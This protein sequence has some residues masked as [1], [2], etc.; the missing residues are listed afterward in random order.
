V[1]SPI[2]TESSEILDTL[3]KDIGTISDK[4]RTRSSSSSSSTSPIKK[5]GDFL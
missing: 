5:K 1:I 4:L 2:I 3:T